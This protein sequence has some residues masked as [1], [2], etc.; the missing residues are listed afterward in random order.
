MQLYKNNHKTTD[1]ITYIYQKHLPV[2]YATD[3]SI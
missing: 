3:I 1:F 2:F